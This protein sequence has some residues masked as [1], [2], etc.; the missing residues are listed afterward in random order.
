MR[1][2]TR[3]YRHTS[4]AFASSLISFAPVRHLFKSSSLCSANFSTLSKTVWRAP[5]TSPTLGGIGDRHL[6]RS[7]PRVQCFVLPLPFQEQAPQARGSAQK[8]P[9]ISSATAPSP[10]QRGP[11]TTEATSRSG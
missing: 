3:P 5:H 10:S 6:P 1:P 9:N 7:V 4:G 11:W 8:T 2:V